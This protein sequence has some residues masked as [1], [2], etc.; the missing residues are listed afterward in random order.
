MQEHDPRALLRE[1]LT[2]INERLVRLDRQVGHRQ[3]ALAADSGEQAVELENAETMVALEQRLKVESRD[4]QDA[5]VRLDQGAYG[6]CERCGEPID[7]RRLS[8]LPATRWC[9][10]CAGAVDST[11]ERR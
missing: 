7:Q 4:V 10:G 9:I 3:E 8:A 5:L 1:M 11:G 6:V 2:S